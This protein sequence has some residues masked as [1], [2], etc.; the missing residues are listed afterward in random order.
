MTL[1][2]SVRTELGLGWFTRCS[3]LVSPAADVLFELSFRVDVHVTDLT[4]ESF[5]L[6]SSQGL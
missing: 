1:G 3:V 5:V 2:G 4:M 6:K